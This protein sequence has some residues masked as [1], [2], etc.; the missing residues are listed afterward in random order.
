MIVHA[1]HPAEPHVTPELDAAIRD[2]LVAAYPQHADVF[3]RHSF[4]GTVP[5]AR[6]LLRD[7]TG[8]LLA[9]L[10]YARRHVM[11]GPHEVLI[12]GVGAVCTHPRV[13]GRGLGKRLFQALLSDL[14]GNRPADFAFLGCRE[15]VVAFYERCGFTR[16]TQRVRYLDPDDDGWVEHPGPN[17]LLPARAPL[18]AWPP[19]GL[20]DLRGLPW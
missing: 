5:E 14:R 6:V 4:W 15:G 11:V 20:I 19:A 1:A 17:M 10:A 16:L 8:A 18:T 12:A 7:D 2:L 13:Q 9:H 3:S